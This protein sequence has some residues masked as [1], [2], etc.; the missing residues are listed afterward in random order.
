MR[1]STVPAPVV[2]PPPPLRED[3]SRVGDCWIVR[4]RT[5]TVMSIEEDLG[6]RKPRFWDGGLVAKR[7]MDSG[8]KMTAGAGTGFVD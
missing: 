6:S 8:M 5:P 4:S 7:I 3:E 2:S 1:G